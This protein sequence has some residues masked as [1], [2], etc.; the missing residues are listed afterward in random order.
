[1]IIFHF[2]LQYW[3]I[4]SSNIFKWFFKIQINGGLKNIYVLSNYAYYNHNISTFNA[5]VV[6]NTILSNQFLT[7]F[8]DTKNFQFLYSSYYKRKE[9]LMVSSFYL[10]RFLI[11]FFLFMSI[12]VL[13]LNWILGKFVFFVYLT[14][15]THAYLP[16]T[17]I[18]WILLRHTS[19]GH[20]AQLQ[21][22]IFIIWLFFY[23]VCSLLSLFVLLWSATFEKIIKIY[24]CSIHILMSSIKQLHWGLWCLDS[25]CKVGNYWILKILLLMSQVEY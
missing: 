5:K 6:L 15:H 3:I 18:S 17:T 23:F 14:L 11:N 16:P 8:Y 19:K 22:K 13:I 7:Y 9:E 4:T 10:Q 20:L 21:S 25:F 2:I 12:F 1:M 24:A